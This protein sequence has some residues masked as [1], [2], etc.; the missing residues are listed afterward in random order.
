MKILNNGRFTGWHMTAILV[1]FF[2]IVMAVNFYMARMALSTF[3]G[4][5]VD[6]SYVASQNYNQWLAASDKQD[7][8]GWTTKAALTAD[9]F[10]IIDVQQNGQPVRDVTAFGV[11]LHPLGRAVD[12]PLSFK[13]MPDGTLRSITALP[14]GRW[15][16]QISLRQ[17]ADIYR[18]VEQIQ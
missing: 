18:F 10:V 15:N 9:R 14:V 3:G 2:G 5:V 17:S 4:T 1:V 12:Q 6:N 7:R 8:L 13:P 11:A 16:V